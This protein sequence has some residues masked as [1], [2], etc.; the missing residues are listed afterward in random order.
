[1]DPASS[2][3]M[4][5]IDEPARAKTRLESAGLLGVAREDR[6]NLGALGRGHRTLA[7]AI[8]ELAQAQLV[9]VLLLESEHRPLPFPRVLGLA[10]GPRSDHVP[11][12]ARAWT[13]GPS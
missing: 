11:V 4:S 12:D 1:M 6:V 9:L 7:L 8:P 2:T 5:L 3:L 10:P 13:H